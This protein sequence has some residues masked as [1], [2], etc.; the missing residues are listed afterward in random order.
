MAYHLFRYYYWLSPACPKVILFIL[1]ILPKSW[2]H[3]LRSRKK[4]VM[5]EVPPPPW[6]N[7]KP[8]WSICIHR[9]L[10]LALWEP[11]SSTP[12]YGFLGMWRTEMEKFHG[13][14][15]QGSL[16]CRNQEIMIVHWKIS[17]WTW[18]N[19]YVLHF[20]FHVAFIFCQLSNLCL[21]KS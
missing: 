16:T 8:T 17:E 2:L 14:T 12:A 1:F 20:V 4:T 7:P 5:G 15:Y 13:S 18:L 19:C 9:V 11:V 3:P 21:W 10:W 6:P